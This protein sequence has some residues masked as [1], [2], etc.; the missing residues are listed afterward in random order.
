MFQV[1]LE[2]SSD[3]F[4][5]F[6]YASE[7][8]VKLC[9]KLLEIT[10]EQQHQ[11]ISTCSRPWES[12]TF[13]DHLSSVTTPLFDFDIKHETMDHLKKFYF[14][15]QKIPHNRWDAITLLEHIRK[16]MI[17]R[18]LSILEPRSFGKD[19]PAFISTWNSVLIN[20]PLR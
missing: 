17:P 19:N 10:M 12:M 5:I 15:L 18:G 3:H 16:E 7:K 20:A 2:F 8:K 6:L 13:K 11:F 9:R 14:S 4:F 1:L